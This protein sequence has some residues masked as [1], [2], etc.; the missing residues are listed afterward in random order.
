MLAL[1]L[2]AGLDSGWRSWKMQATEES[3]EEELLAHAAA[4]D[5]QVL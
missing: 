2:G 1:R 4:M 5:G 3:I